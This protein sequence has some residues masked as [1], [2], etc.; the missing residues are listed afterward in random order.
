MPSFKLRHS[1]SGAKTMS[2]HVT[3]VSGRKLRWGLFSTSP[4]SPPRPITE[5]SVVAQQCM[6]MPSAD[7]RS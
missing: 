6:T 1:C 4:G 7:E 3:P 5:M 2:A